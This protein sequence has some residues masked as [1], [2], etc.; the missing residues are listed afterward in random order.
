MTIYMSAL[1]T[2]ACWILWEVLPSWLFFCRI[3]LCVCKGY[4]DPLDSLAYFE[5]H[6]NFKACNTGQEFDRSHNSTWC[7]LCQ[8]GALTG[9]TPLP[10]WPT[11]ATAWWSSIDLAGHI[12]LGII[13]MSKCFLSSD[14]YVILC[15]LHE[16]DAYSQRDSQIPMVSLQSLKLHS[17]VAGRVM[18]LIPMAMLHC[19]L[20]SA[21]AS[22]GREDLTALCLASDVRGG[23]VS[24]SFHLDPSRLDVCS[25][26]LV[27]R[28]SSIPLLI[29]GFVQSGV[30]NP[31]RCQALGFIYSSISCLGADTN[32]KGATLQQT[33]PSCSTPRQSRLTGM[34]PENYSWRLVDLYCFQCS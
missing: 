24:K 26:F 14:A 10:T 21:T 32:D 5:I 29:V 9:C 30:S 13:P 7:I 12:V 23:F 17:F 20:P 16:P 3:M 2:S 28:S 33:D 19:A 25:C 6:W 1:W 31:L 22:I 27:L 15:M 4:C 8:T 34:T 18:W 11:I